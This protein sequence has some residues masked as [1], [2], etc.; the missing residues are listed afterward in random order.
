MNPH[1]WLLPGRGLL[2]LALLSTLGLAGLSLGRITAPLP[3]L[4]AD[5]DALRGV[6]FPGDKETDGD[7]LREAAQTWADRYTYPTVVYAGHGG[8][9]IQP[10]PG[11]RRQPGHP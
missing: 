2:L 8:P 11:P 4:A 5:P 3:P 1:R 10:D 7:R 9:G 6:P